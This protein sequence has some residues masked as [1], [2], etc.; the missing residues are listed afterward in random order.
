MSISRPPTYARRWGRCSPRQSPS[1]AKRAKGSAL[2]A[3]SAAPLIAASFWRLAG[4]GIHGSVLLGLVRRPVLAPARDDLLEAAYPEDRGQAD[5]ADREG[6][7][8]DR[9]LL[10]DG[11]GRDGVRVRLA[12]E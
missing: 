3:R 9:H 8:G 6:P 10:S 7:C 12:R 5:E 2:R 11:V 4:R 1:C